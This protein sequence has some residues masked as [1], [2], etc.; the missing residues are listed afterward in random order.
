[1]HAFVV[2]HQPQWLSVAQCMQSAWAA[3][4]SSTHAPLEQ[5]CVL[6]HVVLHAPQ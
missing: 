6:V 4:G 5:T 1:M 3:H 2:T